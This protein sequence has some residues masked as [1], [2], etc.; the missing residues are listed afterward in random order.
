MHYGKRHIVDAVKVPAPAGAVDN[1]R[2]ELRI[3]CPFCGVSTLVPSLSEAQLGAWQKKE[4][5]IQQAFPRLSAGYREALIS[6]LCSSCFEK[7]TVEDARDAEAAAADSTPEAEAEAES[8]A[9]IYDSDDD[10]PFD[11]E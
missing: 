6:G 4:M 1:F 3:D 5:S 11:E 8:W 9:Q 2:I 7:A 10:E